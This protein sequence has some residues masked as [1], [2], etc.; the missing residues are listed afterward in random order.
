LPLPPSSY[1]P[2]RVEI[3]WKSEYSPV[4]VEPFR[5]ATG[6]ITAIPVAVA[7]IFQLFFSMA[8]TQLIVEQKNLYASQVMVLSCLPHEHRLQ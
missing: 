5:E 3:E 1:R 8:I 4:Q 7:E 6:P 2:E